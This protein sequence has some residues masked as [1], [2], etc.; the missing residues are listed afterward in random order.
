M[1]TVSESLRDAATSAETWDVDKH[2]DC[3]DHWLFREKP[4]RQMGKIIPN[5]NDVPYG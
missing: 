5:E 3:T 1:K 2:G 4:R